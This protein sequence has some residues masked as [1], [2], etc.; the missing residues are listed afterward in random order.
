MPISGSVIISVE[1]GDD[2]VCALDTAGILYTSGG[3]QDGQLGVE[4]ER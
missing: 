2:Y 4:E 3:N 1:C